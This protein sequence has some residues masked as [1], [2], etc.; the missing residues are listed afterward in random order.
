M[1][2]IYLIR[3]GQASFGSA[4]YDQLSE[5]GQ[6][7]ATRTG[8]Y[9]ARAG[10]SLDAA[11]S[12]DLWRQRET[13]ERVCKELDCDIAHHVDPRFNEIRND[14]QVEHLTPIVAEQNP[15]LKQLLK[16]GLSNSKHYQKLIEAV[17]NYWVS[18]DC[19]AYGIQSWDEY[20]GMA[21]AA[22]AEVMS[23]EGSG[24]TIGIFTSGGTIATLVAHVLGLGGTQTYQFYEPVF[25]CS[26]TQLFYSG[27]NVSLS[28][29]ND[30]SF[31]QLLGKERGEELVSYR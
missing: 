7:Q 24:K 10:V 26:V 3:H 11:Y 4:N 20:S 25:N 31:L 1:A 17:F 28:Y 18:N 22:L 14:E 19:S 6:L 2:T 12:G 8:Q 16:T 15:A 21:Q 13:C 27:E 23:R 30:R 29:F 9:L 5:L